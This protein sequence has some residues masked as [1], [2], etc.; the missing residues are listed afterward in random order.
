VQKQKIIILAIGIILAIVAVFMIT[1]YLNQQKQLMQEKAKM[2]VAQT[3]AN[4]TS[5]LVAKD[6]IPR[7]A[8]IEPDMLT[9]AIVP[10]EYLQPQV[11]TSTDRIAGMVTVAQFAKGEQITLS[12]LTQ[13]K[14]QG[15]G[16]LAEMTP[17]GKRAITVSVDNIASLAGMIRPGD[18]VDVIAMVPVPV[19]TADGKQA[20]QVAVMPLFQNV[21]VLAV[22]QDTSTVSKEGASS[23]Y[24]KAET[25]T[26]TSPLITLAL[27]PQEANLIAFVQEQGKIRLA[28][29]SPA[30]SQV[31]QVQPASWDTL[32]QYIMPKDASKP[33]AAEEAAT[34]YV[35]VYRGLNKERVPIS[36]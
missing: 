11:V 7:G 19:Q 24:K 31:Q 12:K 6:D 33:E 8:T 2:V 25:T 34:S 26:E 22:G 16:G 20:T 36:K 35:E 4:Q 3:L 28:L 21:L 1:V 23:R 13:P 27:G 14:Q 30:D 18:Y 17:I 5:V 10:N 29:R 32:F 9:A 15:G